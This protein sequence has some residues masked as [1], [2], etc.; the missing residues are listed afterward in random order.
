MADA[1]EYLREEYA[2]EYLDILF[3]KNP[4]GKDLN[5]AQKSDYFLK[6]PVQGFELNIGA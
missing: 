4:S 1:Y 3:E 6:V 5:F 2:E